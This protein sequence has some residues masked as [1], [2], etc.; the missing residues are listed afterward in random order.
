MATIWA[1]WG[2]KQYFLGF[3]NLEWF[4]AETGLSAVA[5]DHMLHGDTR[6]FGF[7]SGVS[8]FTVIP[9]YLCYGVWHTLQHR[10]HRLLFMGCTAILFCGVL[11]SLQRTMLVVPCLVVA[12]YFLLQTLRR[13]AISYALCLGTFILAVFN[14]EYLLLHLDDINEVISV[15]GYWGQNMLNVGTYE[16]RLHSWLYLKDPASYSLFGLP[17]SISRSHDVITETLANYGV[18]GVLLA[19]VIVTFGLWFVQ[20]AVLRVE[21]PQDR[22]FAIFMLAVTV[23]SVGTGII[24]GGNFTA[25]PVNLQT[26]SFFGA[27]IALAVNSRL[28]PIT[29]RKTARELLEAFQAAGPKVPLAAQGRLVQAKAEASPA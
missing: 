16:A 5:S 24:G 13:S 18:V 17:E 27:C 11:A 9:A 28:A 20:R 26:W 15:D 1:V 12:F 3:T 7:G 10:K 19:F 22:K 14:A 4:Y 8:N 21:D 29:T 23:P 25:N 2:I 6:P